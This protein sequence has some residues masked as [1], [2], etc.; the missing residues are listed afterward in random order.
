MM[1]YPEHLQNWEYLIIPES[2]RDRLLDLGTQGWELV[3][4]GGDATQPLLYLKRPG[5][6]FRERV[7]LQQREAYLGTQST[8]STGAAGS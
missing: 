3:A 6:T 5:L 1:A 7:T 2:D 8:S 4:I